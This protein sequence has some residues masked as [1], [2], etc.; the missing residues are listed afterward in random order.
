MKNTLHLINKPLIENV[1]KNKEFHCSCIIA[2]LNL[3][4]YCIL[5]TSIDK[6]KRK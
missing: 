4:L 1:P 5:N 6:I 2:E 3:Y